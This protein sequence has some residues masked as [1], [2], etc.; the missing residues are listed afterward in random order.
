MASCRPRALGKAVYQAV[1]GEGRS[2]IPKELSA[3]MVPQ[4]LAA[5]AARS[6]GVPSLLHTFTRLTPPTTLLL[7]SSSPPLLLS[8]SP[9]LLLSSSPPLLLS[10]AF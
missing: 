8:S 6:V 7:L 2:D 10:S 9:P 5:L 3:P 4:L 1:L